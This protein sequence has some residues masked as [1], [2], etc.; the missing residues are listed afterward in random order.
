VAHDHSAWNPDR[1]R[2]IRKKY[3]NIHQSDFNDLSEML[4]AHKEEVTS[5]LLEFTKGWRDQVKKEETKLARSVVYT[6]AQNASSALQHRQE[7]IPVR[8]SP[9]ESSSLKSPVRMPPVGLFSVSSP[10]GKRS[11]DKYMGNM[12]GGSGS[13]MMGS[14]SR[15]M[16]HSYQ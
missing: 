6:N 10:Q 11:P 8:G 2:R 7:D 12:G 9:S 1:I 15:R 5:K 13:P 4:V 14:P 3:G 16:P